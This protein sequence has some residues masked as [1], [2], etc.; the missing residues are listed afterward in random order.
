M[1]RSIE[2]AVDGELDNSTHNMVTLSIF[3]HILKTRC[4][5]KIIDKFSVK[6]GILFDGS[7]PCSV[8]FRELSQGYG[9][10]GACLHRSFESL[11]FHDC[12]SRFTTVFMKK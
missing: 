2:K 9:L 3:S 11:D 5:E 4:E 1:R 7:S 8:A 6:S 10:R 12:S